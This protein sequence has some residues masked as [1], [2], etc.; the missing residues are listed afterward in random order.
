MDG[1]CSTHGRNGNVY[2]I[3]VE[4]PE[5]KGPREDLSVQD[6]I[7]MDLKCVGSVRTGFIWL[8]IG[9]SGRLL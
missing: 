6:N 3:L 4:K 2:K 8:R 5:R 7:R 1:K 9:T